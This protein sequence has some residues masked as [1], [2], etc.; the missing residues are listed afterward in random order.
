VLAP[1]SAESPSW[2][3]AVQLRDRARQAIAA[4]TD[5]AIID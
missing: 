2:T 1:L 3:A 4:A 5:E